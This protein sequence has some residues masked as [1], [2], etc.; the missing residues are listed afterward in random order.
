MLTAA[1]KDGH[2]EIVRILLQHYADI[3][4]GDLVRSNRTFLYNFKK[5]LYLIYVNIYNPCFLLDRMKYSIQKFRTK[6][7]HVTDLTACN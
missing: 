1:C 6:S 7:I 4:A 2:V 3:E 5:G